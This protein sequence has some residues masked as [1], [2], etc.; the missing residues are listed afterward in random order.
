MKS[1]IVLENGK[2][3]EGVRIGSKRNSIFG[4]Q[5]QE[6]DT[7]ETGKSAGLDRKG[8]NAGVAF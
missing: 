2:I 5:V 7:R 3:F 8:F 1:Y 4:T 6:C